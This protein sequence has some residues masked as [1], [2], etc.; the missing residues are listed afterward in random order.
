[1]SARGV[2]YHRVD[3]NAIP[4]P[5]PSNLPLRC[6]SNENLVYYFFDIISYY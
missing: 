5:N 1:M 4:T 2:T 6:Q 3:G